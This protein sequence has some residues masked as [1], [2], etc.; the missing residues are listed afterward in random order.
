LT[1][2]NGCPLDFS[3][4]TTYEA[5][6]KVSVEG[7]GVEKLVYQC[8]TFPDSGYCNQ[9]EPGHWS[10]LGWKLLGYCEGK[11]V[12]SSYI[13]TAWLNSFLIVSLSLH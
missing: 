11:F 1:D 2:Q 5:G 7:N 10:K 6:D 13:F 12:T 9:Y 3:S 8:K 4:S